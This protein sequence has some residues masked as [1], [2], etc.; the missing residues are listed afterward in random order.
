M[1]TE[2]CFLV[3]NVIDSQ[4]IPQKIAPQ[5]F[6]RIEGCHLM[7]GNKPIGHIVAKV[8]G[9]AIHN[10]RRYVTLAV[11]CLRSGH[12]Q[13]LPIPYKVFSNPCRLRAQ[14]DSLSGVDVAAYPRMAT[15]LQRAI[16]SMSKATRQGLGKV[17]R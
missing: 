9:E 6:Y 11:R 10:G 13:L 5:S 1:I 17:A 12:K 16:V 15:A 4:S 14:L 7:A 2:N 3:N 8:I